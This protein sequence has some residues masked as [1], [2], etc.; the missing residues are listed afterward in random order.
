MLNLVCA[1]TCSSLATFICLSAKL[2]SLVLKIFER[3]LNKCGCESYMF[4][5][6]SNVLL[7]CFVLFSDVIVENI[8]VKNRS[9]DWYVQL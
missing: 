1:F 3:G 5:V 9:T 8:W 4:A 2:A 6:V 7:F